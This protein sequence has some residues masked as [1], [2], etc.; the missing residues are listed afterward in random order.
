MRHSYPSL[1]GCVG[2]EWP[3]VAIPVDSIG[4]EDRMAM[5]DS[6]IRDYHHR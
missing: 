3:I 5:F 2:Q 6:H 4:K 1:V